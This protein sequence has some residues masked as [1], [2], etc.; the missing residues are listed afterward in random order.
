MKKKKVE[1]YHIFRKVAIAAFISPEQMLVRKMPYKSL[2]YYEFPQSDILY[3]DLPTVM[4]SQEE[5]VIDV[6]SYFKNEQDFIKRTMN[7]TCKRIIRNV[8]GE[9]ISE[10]G[11]MNEFK[12]KVYES[13]FNMATNTFT[14]L[15]KCHE[16]IKAGDFS[17]QKLKS[18]SLQKMDDMLREK[19]EKFVGECCRLA[20]RIRK[21]PTEILANNVK[22][23]K[24]T[25]E[26]FMEKDR[27]LFYK[28]IF[29]VH[30]D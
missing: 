7:N 17:F 20:P 15:I 28:D 6:E 27:T 5:P 18:N 1:D 12:A 13:F 16:E 8:L 22:P 26:D 25:H 29:I 30:R 2:E 19:V 23:I 14:I 24:L 9:K 4:N 10:K 11:Q 3:E 21:A